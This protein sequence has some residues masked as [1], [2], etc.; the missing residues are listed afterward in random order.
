MNFSSPLVSEFVATGRCAD[1]PIINTH[2]HFGPYKA[3]YFPHAAPEQVLAMMARA[4]VR[5]LIAAAHSAL[6]DTQRG[7]RWYHAI[8]RQHPDRFRGYWAI[9]PN[10]PERVRQEVAEFDQF[11]GMVGF[12]FLSDYY[13]YPVTGEA[14]AP[15]LDTQRL[16]HERVLEGQLPAGHVGALLLV[17][18]E[19]VITVSQRQGSSRHLLASPQRL[20][21]LGIAPATVKRDWT[22]ASAWLRRAISA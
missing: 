19:P 1:C 2:A 18:H 14:Y 17:E 9:N 5:W 8:L 7:N 16:T 21:A 12:K 3:I 20:A 10:Y 4:G 15:A 11:P 22:Y 13:Q 6:V